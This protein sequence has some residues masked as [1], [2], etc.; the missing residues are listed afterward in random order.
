MVDKNYGPRDLSPWARG[1]ETA[2]RQ[3]MSPQ[4]IGCVPDV[5]KEK[6]NQ[7]MEQE[8]DEEDQVQSEDEDDM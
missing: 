7:D 1:C 3:I 2:E 4:S 8:I 6:E 5:N